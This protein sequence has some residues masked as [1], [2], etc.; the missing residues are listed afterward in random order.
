MEFEHVGVDVVV[1]DQEAVFFA[2]KPASA[3]GKSDG[4]RL[5]AYLVLDVVNVPHVPLQLDGLFPNELEGRVRGGL[6]AARDAWDRIDRLILREK[7][8]LEVGGD[9][10]LRAPVV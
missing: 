9:W 4:P 1:A 5:L 3:A 8:K 6:E 10:L 2:L 7:G